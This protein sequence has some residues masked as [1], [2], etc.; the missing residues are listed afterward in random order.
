MSLGSFLLV[1]PELGVAICD[2]DRELLS[3]LD[4]LFALASGDIVRNLS[5]ENAVLHH[6]HLKLLHVEDT[7][8]AQAVGQDV[9]VL[10]VGAVTD[11]GHRNGTTELPPH[12]AINTTRA[13]PRSVDA[14][15]PVGLEAC[16]LL[17]PLHSLLHLLQR[18]GGHHFP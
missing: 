9:A 14:H 7:E 15:E 13:P 16:E 2:G 3:T 18:L 8:L 1:R 4:N 11:V 5:A 12:P 10:L 6:E 17:L